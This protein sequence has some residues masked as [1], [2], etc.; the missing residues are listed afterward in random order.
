MAEK[1]EVLKLGVEGGGATVF[2]TL[3]A[4]GA[5]KFHV[6]GSS[7]YLDENDDEGWRSW[8]TEPVKTI[9]EALRSVAEDGSWVAFHPISVHPD[10]GA[11]VWELAQSTAR[12]LPDE[13]SG[14]W[15]RKSEIWKRRCLEQR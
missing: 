2:R 11:T 10:Y 8:T 7:M 1:E 3:V 4:G 14:V 5:S 13:M 15:K 6:E 12:T 9:E